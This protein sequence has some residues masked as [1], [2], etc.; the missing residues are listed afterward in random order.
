VEGELADKRVI[1]LSVR[2]LHMA[3]VTDAGEWYTW[4]DRTFG[5]L[6]LGST[7]S[8]HELRQVSG[9]LRG[10]RIVEVA[11]GTFHTTAV[12]LECESCT[13]GR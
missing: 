5:M 10:K 6:G 8:R 2:A 7:Y 13:F 4:S 3:V 1:K 12:T 11:C 9:V